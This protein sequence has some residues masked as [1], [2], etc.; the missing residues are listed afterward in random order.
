MLDMHVRPS[1]VMGID[2]VYTAFCF[3]EAC[4]LILT[5]LNDG[6]KPIL[7]TENKKEYSRPSDIYKKFSS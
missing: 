3:D 1:E 4:A 2:D 6:Q 5:K 7:K